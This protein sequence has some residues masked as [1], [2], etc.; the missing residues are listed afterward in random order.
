M[1]EPEPHL[2]ALRVLEFVIALVIL[3]GLLGA[4]VYGLIGRAWFGA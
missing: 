1:T 2:S 4:W 3:L